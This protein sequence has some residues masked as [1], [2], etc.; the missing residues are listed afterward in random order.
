MKFSLSPVRRRVDT[1]ECLHR[2]RRDR[3]WSQ[4]RGSTKE[5]AQKKRGLQQLA[6]LDQRLQAQAEELAHLE[7]QLAEPVV[8]GNGGEFRRLSERHAALRADRE[9]VEAEWLSLYEQLE[10]RTANDQPVAG[11]TGNRRSA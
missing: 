7:S 5:N 8:N 11:P 2:H 6:L 10:A 1:S 3:P 9:T 4:D